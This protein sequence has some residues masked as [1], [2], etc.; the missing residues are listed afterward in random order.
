M[1]DAVVDETC[2]HTFILLVSSPFWMTSAWVPKKGAAGLL[3]DAASTI[4]TAAALMAIAGNAQMRNIT[5]SS[6]FLPSV[7]D[8]AAL[9]R[10]NRATKTVQ[11]SVYLSTVPV[12]AANIAYGLVAC[13]RPLPKWTFWSMPVASVAWSTGT[14]A[15]NMLWL[16]TNKLAGEL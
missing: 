13:R 2:W 14:I 3:A 1:R 11:K 4:S 7:E 15:W 12:L 9:A 5:A 8:R 16:P 10:A 6:S